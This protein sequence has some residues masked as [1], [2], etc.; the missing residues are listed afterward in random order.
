M[1]LQKRMEGI[2]EEA[3]KR[4]EGGPKLKKEIAHLEKTFSLD[5]G[6]EVYSVKIKDSKIYDFEP[7]L[8][9]DADVIVTSKPEHIEALIDGELRPMRAYIT[10][11]VQFKGK[12][13]DL[14]FLKKFL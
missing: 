8:T 2:V 11:K 12:I 7:V 4:I 5:L 1:S 3:N 14:L 10:K 9:E 6:E 13:N